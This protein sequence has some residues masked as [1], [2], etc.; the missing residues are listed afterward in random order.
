VHWGQSKVA[1]DSLFRG[2]IVDSPWMEIDT[3]DRS[4]FRNCI[5][6]SWTDFNST[7]TKS[8]ASVAHSCGGATWTRVAVDTS[9]SIP[10]ID[11][12]TDLAIGSDGT[13]YLSW[14]RC[15]T[16]GPAGDCGDTDV[17]M[18]F[19]RST[20]GGNTWTAS[21]LIAPAHTAPDT[22][23]CY[24][25]CFDDTSEPVPNTPSMDFDN[26]TGA[27]WVAFY[28]SSTTDAGG[29]PDA[30]PALDRHSKLP[31]FNSG[32]GGTTWVPKVPPPV[33]AVNAGWIWLSTND[34]GR[35][36]VSYLFS[37]ASGTYS[38]GV[39][40]SMDGTTWVIRTLSAP[41]AM[42]FSSDGFGGTFI[43]GR[44]GS[45]WTANTLHVAWMDTHTGGV[46]SDMTGG[47][48]T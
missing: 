29:S 20:D 25:G 15:N 38:A 34:A 4:S 42:L 12:F 23:G 19:S 11:Q 33:P 35:I 37:E 13:V 43:G 8:R 26:S 5:Y 44:T 27:L 21:T 32:N 30:S 31:V 7:L 24:Y 41:P 47:V 1:F 16:S 14:M 9:Q 22:A 36:A 48:S 45:I 3:N 17:D 46:S 28:T 39:A 18:R 10:K 6:V 2:G 40:L